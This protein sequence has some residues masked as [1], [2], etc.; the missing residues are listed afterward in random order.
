[1]AF[2]VDIPTERTIGDDNGPW[3]NVG[4]FKTKE[5]AVQWIRDNIGPCDEEGRIELITDCPQWDEEDDGFM[6]QQKNR[7]GETGKKG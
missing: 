7:V 3:L 2:L 5:E 1:M 4:Q 6:T